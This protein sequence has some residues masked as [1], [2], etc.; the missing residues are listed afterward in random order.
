MITKELIA[1]YLEFR[2]EVQESTKRSSIRPVLNSLMDFEKEFGKSLCNFSKEDFEVVFV[3]KDWVGGGFK[4]KK[5]VVKNFIQWDVD[6]NGVLYGIDFDTFVLDDNVQFKFYKSAYFETEKDFVESLKYLLARKEKLVRGLAICALYWAGFS[7]Q[8]IVNIKIDDM[9]E[10]SHTIC[11]RKVSCDLYDFIKDCASIKSYSFGISNMAT[12]T[13]T[14][15]NTGYVIRLGEDSVSSNKKTVTIDVLR[16]QVCYIGEEI[17]TL[18][19]G[20][21]LYG[22]RFNQK[23]LNRN[24]EFCKM[25]D[26]ELSIGDPHFFESVTFSEVEDFFRNVCYDKAIKSVGYRWMTNSYKIWKKCYK[27]E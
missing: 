6:I 11:G 24:G 1:D 17:D 14:F 16:K 4:S 9:D 8:E 26:Y 13:K 15:A 12:V 7:R 21:K 25:Y 10:Q 22:K 3:E 27:D 2:S 23:F 5:S 18:L 20:D 19:P